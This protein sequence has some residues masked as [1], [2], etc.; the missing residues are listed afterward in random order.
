MDTESIVAVIIAF[1]L[2]ILVIFMYSKFKNSSLIK[3]DD[4]K[5]NDKE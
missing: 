5:D 1:C 4:E 2:L 3:F